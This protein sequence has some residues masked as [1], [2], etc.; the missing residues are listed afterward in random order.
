MITTVPCLQ[1]DKASLQGA[2]LTG[3][4]LAWVCK[5]HLRALG[6][7]LGAKVVLEVRNPS[8]LPSVARVLVLARSHYCRPAHADPSACTATDMT[9]SFGSALGSV[10]DEVGGVRQTGTITAVG[11]GYWS[12]WVEV[13]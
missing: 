11:S 8:R 2:W 12:E 4:P 10:Q 6:R 3:A 13:M 1:A 5:M 7:R 9:A